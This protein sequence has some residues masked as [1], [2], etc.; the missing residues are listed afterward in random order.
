MTPALFYMKFDLKLNTKVKES[1]PRFLLI[2]YTSPLHQWFRS[3]GILR[4][5]KTTETVSGQNSGGTVF[6]FSSL[7]Y[8]E[9]PEVSNTISE[10][11]SLSFLVVH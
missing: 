7:G 6:N 5:D 4:N 11:N 3:Y 9:T 10:D 8:A 2:T 1:S